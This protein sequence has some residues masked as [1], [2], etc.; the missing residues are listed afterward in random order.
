MGLCHAESFDY[1]K[2]LIRAVG[3]MDEHSMIIASDGVRF[4]IVFA[5]LSLTSKARYRVGGAAS[6]PKPYLFN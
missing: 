4:N 5:S 6:E 3:Y 2:I 1:S